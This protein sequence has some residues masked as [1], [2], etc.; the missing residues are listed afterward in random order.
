[1]DCSM[2]GCPS[3]SPKVYPSSCP[4]C[5]WC[6]PANVILWCPLLFLPSIFPSN[7][8][9]SNESAVCFR[10]PKYWTCSVSP[11]KYSGLISLKIDWFD[12]LAVQ[13]TF[14][15]FLQHHSSKTS[16]LWHF[17]F[18]MVQLSHPYLTTVKTITLTIWTFVNRV[19]SLLFNTVYKCYLQLFTMFFFSFFLQFLQCYFTIIPVFQH[20]VIS[21]IYNYSSV[22]GFGLHFSS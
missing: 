4:L 1:M 14:R 20:T 13:G 2:S 8:G 9:F 17:A 3:P 7:R 22:P 6:H 10:W 16:I 19:M 5:Q 21:V 18:F 12:L 15:S 11:S